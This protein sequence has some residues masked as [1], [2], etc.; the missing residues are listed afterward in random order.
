MIAEGFRGNDLI[1]RHDGGIYVTNPIRDGGEPS[2]VWYI[3]P[4]RR[5]EGRRHR[6]DLPERRR[7]LARPVAAL[8]RRLPDPLGLQ[9]PDPAPTARWRTSRS[10]ITCTSPT[11]P[12]TAAPTAWPS[13]ATAGSTSRRGWA[14]RSA[15]RPAASTASSRRPNGRV[16]NLCFGGAD[17]DTL[18]ATCGDRVYQRKVKVR[19]APALRAADHAREAAPLI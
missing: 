14:S 5:E 15:T 16:S 12:T 17:F 18:F 7:A 2:K 1:V 10:I 4:G 9:L 3:R 6:P 13:I 19:G 11:P 8:R